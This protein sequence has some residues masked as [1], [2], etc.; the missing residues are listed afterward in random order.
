[1]ALRENGLVDSVTALALRARDGDRPALTRFIQLTQGDVWRMCRHMVDANSADDL[2]QDVF[3][4]AISALHR[5]TPE[6]NAKSWLLG[7]ARHVCIDEIRRRVRRTKRDNLY[8]ATFD[9]SAEAVNDLPIEWREQLSALDEDKRLA[10][11]LTQVVGLSY[12]EAAEVA[13]CPIGT[14]RS[15]VARARLEL[16]DAVVRLDSNNR[17]S[18]AV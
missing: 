4:R 1:M 3:E 17:S 9:E 11:V 2:T 12:E 6:S 5:L 8:R 13:G 16:L 10:F 14:I 18:D 15:R 7:V